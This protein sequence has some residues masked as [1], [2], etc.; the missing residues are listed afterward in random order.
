MGDLQV[1]QNN[2]K[3][4]AF[5]FFTAEDLGKDE[6]NM[7]ALKL[8]TSRLDN[9]D[10]RKILGSLSA[11]DKWDALAKI[12]QCSTD[13]KH[14]RIAALFQDYDNF[15]MGEKE[16]IEDFQARFLTL[17]NSLSYLGEQIA[18]W[19]QVNKVLQSLNSSWDPIAINVQT[20]PHTKE[21]DI[22]EFFGKLC[23]FNGLQKRREAPKL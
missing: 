20:Q 22:D 7:K 21:L 18:N 15:A 14:D 17:I 9:S 23:A 3:L 12:Y 10:R 8:L 16:S 1:T 6:K 5:T 13:V 4:V 19:K 11:K 2:G